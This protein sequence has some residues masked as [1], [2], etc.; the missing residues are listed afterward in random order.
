VLP[1]K[2][3]TSNFESQSFAGTGGGVVAA[4]FLTAVVPRHGATWHPIIRTND[5]ESLT[6][7]FV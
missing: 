7:L 1:E 3:G 2:Q 5:Q 6:N 4:M